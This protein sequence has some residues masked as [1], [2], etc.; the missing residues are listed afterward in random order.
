MTTETPIFTVLHTITPRALLPTDRVDILLVMPR[1][2]RAPGST[3]ISAP[4]NADPMKSVRPRT[5]HT[6]NVD[7]Q[8]TTTC[9]AT[10]RQGES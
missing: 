9:A 4:Y 10:T 8:P 1:A 7:K 2:I 3:A 5:N 6:T